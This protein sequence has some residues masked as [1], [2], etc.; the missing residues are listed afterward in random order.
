MTDIVLINIKLYTMT[1]K[2][3]NIKGSTSNLFSEVSTH[4]KLVDF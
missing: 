2:L 1:E 4:E 3:Y